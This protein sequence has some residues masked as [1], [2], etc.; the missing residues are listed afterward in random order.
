MAF[1]GEI[2]AQTRALLWRP[3]Q[4]QVIFSDTIAEAAG[5]VPNWWQLTDFDSS[6]THAFENPTIPTQTE[7]PI[8]LRPWF[9]DYGLVLV[10]DLL[11]SRNDRVSGLH[12]H[13]NLHP[14]IKEEILQSGRAV[15]AV[16]NR[17]PRDEASTEHG[18]N[19]KDFH[20]AVTDSGLE[21]YTTPLDFLDGLERRH[22]ITGL[23][24]APN[25]N[26]P[27]FDGEHEQFRSARIRNTRKNADHLEP[28]FEYPDRAAVI[29]AKQ[30]G[31]HPNVI[32]MDNR[33]GR[34]SF[35]CRFG[36]VKVELIDTSKFSALKEGDSAE[37]VINNMGESYRFDV[38]KSSDL[39][40]S[41]LKE[42]AIYSNCSDQHDPGSQ[43]GFIDLAARVND[44]PSRSR[45]TAYFQ[46][47]NQIPDLDPATAEVQLLA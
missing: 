17:A 31:T 19:G 22:R 34:I 8:G 7:I 4:G 29:A 21:I 6:L 43:T 36:I 24:R 3:T 18:A 30:N 38:T 20:V 14:D 13:G 39:A 28:V 32:P 9:A 45:D 41:P 16:A 46:L 23:Y 5:D 25:K 1:Q 15:I 2:S 40:R 35:V 44:D 10:D 33:E 26:H 42:L 37:I 12:L 27:A 11:R 47:M